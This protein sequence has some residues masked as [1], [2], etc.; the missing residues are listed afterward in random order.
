M[1]R[2]AISRS[3]KKRVS[4]THVSGLAS[5]KPSG[6]RSKDNV[7][8]FGSLTRKQ[9]QDLKE[10]GELIPRDFIDEEEEEEGG[11]PKYVY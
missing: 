6:K 2:S 11:K 5:S 3:M 8:K 10:Y 4:G 1:G 9:Q 7:I